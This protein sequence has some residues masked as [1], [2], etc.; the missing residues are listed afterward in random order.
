MKVLKQFVDS[1]SIH[2]Y[3]IFKISEC[4]EKALEEKCNLILKQQSL[5]WKRLRLEYSE[6]LKVFTMIY[7]YEK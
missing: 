6:S 4:T 1:N 2:N 3:V 5:N 7:Y